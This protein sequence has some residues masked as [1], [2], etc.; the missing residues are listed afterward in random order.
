M[1]LSLIKNAGFNDGEKHWTFQKAADKSIELLDAKL[2]PYSKQKYYP[3][4]FPEFTEYFDGQKWV[5]FPGKFVVT[6]RNDKK[7][8]L[9]LNCINFPIIKSEKADRGT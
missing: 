1:E 5:Y 4:S 3:T 6:A 2:L 7:P 8:N 9:I